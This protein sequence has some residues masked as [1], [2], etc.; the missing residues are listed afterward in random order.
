MVVSL[1]RTLAALQICP[2]EETSDRA[3]GPLPIAPSFDYS[4]RLGFP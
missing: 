2:N 4:P 1:R 3:S